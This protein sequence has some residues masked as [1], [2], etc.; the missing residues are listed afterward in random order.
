MNKDTKKS[1][2]YQ[3]NLTQG[4]CQKDTHKNLTQESKIICK[5]ITRLATGRKEL[6]HGKR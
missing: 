6:N 3:S 5:K 4:E 1:S 2:K